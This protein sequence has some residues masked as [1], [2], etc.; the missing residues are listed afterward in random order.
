MAPGLLQNQC[1]IYLY[2]FISNLPN[3]CFDIL[4]K[5]LLIIYLILLL[6]RFTEHGI[7]DVYSYGIMLIE[8]F[9]SKK[10]TGEIFTAESSLKRWV[11]NM[12]LI[13]FM[14]VVDTNLLS[15]DVWSQRS[16]VLYL[17]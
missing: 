7:E 12:L 4:F 9:S 16:N 6:T 3:Y 5:I 11:S 14:K 10:P 2:I 1:Y 17:Y 13:S 8:T 15:E